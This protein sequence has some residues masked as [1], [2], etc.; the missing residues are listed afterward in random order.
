MDTKNNVTKVNSGLHTDTDPVNQP[1]N[2]YRYALNAVIETKDGQQGNISNELSNFECTTKPNGFEIIGNVYIGDDT[3]GVILVNP[4]TGDEQIG[5]LTKGSKYVPIVETKVLGLKI[6][7]QCDIIFRL[8]RGS[9]RIIYWVDG[10]NLARTFNYDRPHN[11]YNQAYQGYLKLGGNPNNYVGEKWDIDSFN[12]IKSYSS[13]PFFSNIEILETGNILPGSYNF[14]IQYV[15]EDLNPTEWINVSNTINIYND[16]TNNPY[17]KIR[18][19]R[20]TQSDAQTWGRASKSIKLTITNLDSSFPYY[21][22]AIIQANG[23][24]GTPNK[25][26][27]SDLYSTSDSNFIY[28]GNDE[29]LSEIPIG[30]ILID[31]QII[32]APKHIE[33]L[34][35]RLQLANG[36]GKGIDWCK[37]QAYASKIGS[38]IAYKDVIL[39][40]IASD[41]NV[42][43]AKST[44]LFRGYMPGEVYS[45]GIVYLFNDGTLSPAF[46][47][48]GKSLTNTT[49]SMKVYEITNRYLDIHNCAINNYWAQDSEGNSLVGKKIRQHRFPF[50]KEVNKPLY[51]RT[52][53]L[54]NINRYKLTV[55]IT[56]N[57]SWTPGPV[58]YPT[59][60]SDPALIPYTIN[61]VVNGSPTVFDFNGLLVDTDINVP[62]TIYDDT[63]QLTET[64]PGI[65][66]T[67]N[68]SS[69]LATTYQVPGN[70]RFILTF[71]YAPYVSSSSIDNDVSQIFGIEFSNVQKPHP[72]V[73]GFYIVRCERGDD[74]RMIL[75]NA[76]FGAMTQFDQ[77]KSFGL[78]MPKQYYTANNCG[79]V[80]NSGKT[81]NYFDKGTW[82]F[83]PE[84]QYFKKKT[85][86]DRIEVEGTYSESTVQMPTISN[87][88][89][90]TCNEGGT[91]GVYINDVQAGTSYNPEIHK[92]KDK[93]DDGFDLV[94]GYRNTNLTYAINNSLVFPSKSRIFYLNA[95][96]YQN[97]AGD[98][99]YN[100]SVDNKIGMYLTNIAIDTQIFYNNTTKKNHLIYGSLVR[101]GLN[102]YSNFMTRP[103]YKEHNNPVLF[104]NSNTVND[105]EIFNGDAQI[106]AMNFVSSVFYDMVVGSRDKKSRVWK[107]VVGAVL[108]VVGVVVAVYTGGA[109]LAIS[110]AGAALIAGLA[111]SYGVSLLSSGIKF[112]QFKKM[113]DTDY[114]KGLK[115]TVVDGGV[116]ETIRDTL[117]GSNKDDTIRWFSDR[118]SNIYIESTV[119]FGL[120]SG[121]TAGVPDF[122]DAPVQYDE[123]EF[124][125]YLTEKLTVIDRDQGSGRLY[126]GYTTAEIYDMNLDFMR[127]NKQKQFSHLPVEYDCCS[128]SNEKFPL[129]IWWSEQSFQEEKIDNYR[130]F[131]PNNYKDIEGEHGEITDLYRLGNALFVHTRECLWQLPQNHQERVTNEIVSFIGTGSFFDIPPRKAIDDTLG[132]GG[133]QHKWATVKT[134]HG[135]F[136]INETE[137]KIY[138][139]AEKIS[140]ISIK[141]ERNWFEENLKSFLSKQFYDNLGLDYPYDNNPCNP[142]GVGY[143]ATYDSRYE[144]IIIT[145]R[146]Y[147]YLGDFTKVVIYKPNVTYPVG[148]IYVKETGF[149]RVLALSPYTVQQLPFSNKDI[150]EN[151][152]WTKSFSFHTGTWISYHS[153]IANTYIHSQNNLYSVIANNNSI[154]K[155]HKEGEFG[156]FY[157]VQSPYIIEYVPIANPG[158]DKILEFITLYTR[159]RKWDNNTKEYIEKDLIT[160]NK[161]IAFNSKQSSGEHIMIV[162]DNQANT[163]LWLQQQLVNVAGSILITKEEKSWNINELRDYVINYNVPLFSKSW[164]VL[165]S[166]FY[167]DKVVNNA[168]INI[169]KPWQEVQSLKDKYVV[170]RLKFDNF[171]DINLTLIFSEEHQQPV[172]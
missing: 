125:S 118:V 97:F 28:T 114:E 157:G 108:I 41:P 121:L 67:L 13:V 129:R 16:N 51:T 120:R 30:D 11:F 12:L 36:R 163:G 82:F 142:N 74:D 166:E 127:F 63:T 40:N 137:N 65:R 75:D 50:R 14:A 83:N 64:S 117:Q 95:A 111:I 26:L 81:V 160:F 140:D 54:I 39:N 47:I 5:I 61:Y 94:I 105:V 126:K 139:H 151:K 84:F 56:L 102:L 46:H 141:G 55:T 9:E 104:G 150:F 58:A 156:I 85:E 33:Q 122:V 59:S 29:N 148:T 70:N 165:K 93:D 78:I 123:K 170:I 20:N 45:F 77:Y 62:I 96:T 145:K 98:T 15:D 136:F 48:P 88:D 21:R 49:S 113:I 91:K 115:D 159:A 134:K 162:K 132:S 152:S 89:N 73:V 1:K 131:L 147:L 167:I 116:Y 25:T 42:K 119:P 109:G 35:N 135:V 10:N 154:F 34:E 153:Y 57:P 44:F 149:Y 99:Y 146:D 100:V 4:I 27:A 168:A 106:S 107:I 31:Q 6:S 71:N 128:D 23:N 112:E 7:N 110:S 43:N 101:N 32:F 171:N 161:I 68:T 8:R 66:A 80:Q 53:S 22:M 69:T 24:V 133:T 76:I 87:Q 92:K 60:G 138:L 19:S 169:N 86:F 124:R 17:E 155:H 18:G 79:F 38:D 143:T 90:S 103:Y 158:I 3:S 37:F 164:A 130:V 172:V 52:S 2:T 144:R 72:N